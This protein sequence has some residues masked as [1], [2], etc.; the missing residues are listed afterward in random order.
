MSSEPLL[1]RPSLH[2]AVRQGWL[3]SLTGRL[4]AF[5]PAT[6]DAELQ[7]RARIS[8]GFAAVAA[9]LV[10]V[11]A[12]VNLVVARPQ[13]ASITL[14]LLVAILPIPLL[15]RRYAAV[16]SAGLLLNG[17]ILVVIQ[18]AADIRGGLQS[19]TLGWAPVCVVIAVLTLS[20][21]GAVGMTLVWA[22]CHF[23][24]ALRVDPAHWNAARLG[25][26]LLYAIPRALACIAT[27]GLVSIFESAR[28]QAFARLSAE[29]EEIRKQR[30]EI[31]SI[32]ERLAFRNQ[33][34]RLVLD[35]IEQGL[36][37]LDRNALIGAEYSRVVGEWFG[38]IGPGESFISLLRRCDPRAADIFGC[39]WSNLIDEFLPLEL[40]LSQLSTRVACGERVLQL[41][42]KPLAPDSLERGV[43]VVISDITIVLEQA[44]ADV[45]QR[46]TLAIFTRTLQDRSGVRTFFAE[47]QRLVDRI[48]ADEL[49]PEARRDLHT[50][51]GNVAMF[52]LERLARLAHEVED[53]LAAGGA[54]SCEP[55]EQLLQTWSEL[56]AQTAQWLGDGDATLDVARSELEA[57]R[58][59][60]AAG[61][62]RAELSDRLLRW[63]HEDARLR[64]EQLRERALRLAAQLGKPNVRVDVCSNGVRLD[65]ARWGPFW[66]AFVHVVNNA[67]DHGLESSAERESHGKPA[68]G[69]LRLE[70][71][72]TR[73]EVRLR[74]RDD[75]RG[76]DWDAL[77]RKAAALGVMS[78]GVELLFE[79]GL[80]SREQ[81][82]QTS[83][84]GVG[85]WAVKDAAD[86]LGARISVKSEPGRFTEFEFR[87]PI[88]EAHSAGTSR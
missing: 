14:A 75:G 35:T 26:P 33:D 85:M 28:K 9:A 78:S 18:V 86:A 77:N 37:T 82:S 84:R 66:N 44:K 42:V 13:A 64:L 8:L 49:T 10:T 3:R 47:A 45:T 62:P 41:D 23:V 70:L 52:G 74:S 24:H 46:E 76:I 5:L 4:D 80:S 22:A 43:L 16:D 1:P 40:L 32:N 55:R 63:T 6:A 7:R 29:Q 68:F 54:L 83:G 79:P 58:R 39:N 60:V 69:T 72:Q 38:P 57:L 73:D 67:V 61:A 88:N 17:A 15:I 36:V 27:L 20:P 51:K 11:L 48:A 56:R 19:T 59:A 81:A 12:P 34:L 71:E 65:A 2:P 53:H 21:R 25:A 31:A 87:V 30:D 50:F